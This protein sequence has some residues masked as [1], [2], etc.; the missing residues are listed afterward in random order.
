MLRS[1]ACI[2]GLV[3]WIILVPMMGKAV[4]V[5]LA[6]TPAAVQ[7]VVASRTNAGKIG[8]IDRTDEGG[9]TT[10]DVSFTTDSG[11]ERDFS[12]AD[13]GTLLSIEVS[14]GEVPAVVR[15]AIRLQASGW[16]LESLDKNV[17]DPDVTYDVEVSKDGLEKS[18]TIADD[19][20][21]ASREVSLNDLPV[22]AQK[23]VQAHLNG[24]SLTSV[25]ETF[26]EEGTAYDVQ[27]VD[28]DGTGRSFS[29]NTNGT[30][31]S[32][33][34]P[35]EKVAPGARRTIQARIGDGK[36]LRI[37]KS[38]SERRAGVLPYEVQGRKNGEPFDFS[39][40]PRGRFLGMDD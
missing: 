20:T 6:D 39:V 14:L 9:E 21:L 31:V 18:F 16:A 25:D 8:G 7:K 23:S 26:D 37:D 38:L 3:I 2:S 12:L 17:D 40:G 29:I 13:D 11:D 27:A 34:V 36:I 22:A 19:G 32:E 28:V 33:E 15:N 30:L 24:A 1:M 4:P 5:K 35:L 10:F